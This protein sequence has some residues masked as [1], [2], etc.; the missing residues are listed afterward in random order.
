M[1]ELPIDWEYKRINEVCELKS[2]TTIPKALERTH[3]DVL[4]TKVGDMN[5]PDNMV[6]MNT[7]SRFVNRNE[8]KE[9]QIIPEGA[10][11]F[12]KRGGAI[13]TNKKRK[14]VKPT[15]V[16]LNTMAIIPSIKINNDYFYHWF[17]MFDLSKIS[18]GA[19]IPQINNYSFDDIYISF[20]SLP[21]QKRIV[22]ILDEAF[23]SISQAVANAEKNLA[24]ARELYL[25]KKSE[26]FDNLLSDTKV[27]TLPSVCNEIFA[28][29]DAPKKGLFSR[30]KTEKYQIPI[31]ANAVKLNGLYGYTDLSRANK[32]SITIAA[33]GSGTGH[34]ELRRKP[35]LPIVRLIVLT[36][37]EE[38]IRLEYFKH[39]L[40]NLDILRSG[41]AIPQLTVP[42]LKEYSIPLPKLEEQQ[43]II[44]ELEILGG[45][46]D[47]VRK[48]YN[49]KLN[50]LTELKQSILQKAF[51][52]ELTTNDLPKQVN[53]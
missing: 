1:N 42:M 23:A 52:G 36:P 46:I 3:G 51:L 30:S 10:I 12:P 2:G 37:N 9:K 41:S 5:L 50:A 19:N 35:F 47:H 11:I 6:E 39:A 38:V 17:R 14:I 40:Q 13:S 20:P 27:R 24:N 25:S 32:P 8:I 49:Q 34:I 22:N 15:I 18:N 53:G 26:I 29:G 28:G 43:S 21:E 7:S 16:D 4:Y 45:Y 31:Y 44:D 48:I 33:R